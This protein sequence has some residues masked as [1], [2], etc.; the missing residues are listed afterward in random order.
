MLHEP[1]PRTQGQDKAS[2]PKARLGL[3][4]FIGYCAVYAGFVVINTLKPK[5]LEAPGLFGTNLA[6][7]Y[8]FG[9][10]VLAI[11]MGLIYNAICTRLEDR[12]NRSQEGKS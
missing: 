9:L 10:I 6:V 11:V 1:A 5:A 2:A 4:L 3:Q 7:T 8:G 12:A